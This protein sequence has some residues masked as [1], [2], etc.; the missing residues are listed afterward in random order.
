MTAATKFPK[1]YA[2]IVEFFA[3]GSTPESIIKFQLSKEAKE[4]IADLIYAHNNESLSRDEKIELDK[5]VV[6]EHL[7][8]LIKARAYKHVV[9][10]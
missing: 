2:E 7:M 1:A 3:A 8:R 4:H 9:K 5:F 10:E 6:V